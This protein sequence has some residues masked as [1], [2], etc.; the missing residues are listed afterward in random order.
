MMPRHLLKK[1]RSDPIE[2]MERQIR[3][4]EVSED[5]NHDN[6][7]EQRYLAENPDIKKAVEEGKLR[8]G[9]F[10]FKRHGRK[11]HRKQQAGADYGPAIRELR[12]EKATRLEKIFKP[13]VSITRTADG[14]FDFTGEGRKDR[15]NF[16]ETD[17][18]S[19]FFYDR[20]PLDI[21]NGLPDGLILDCGAGF[22]PVYYENVVNYE[23]VP[24][25]TTDVLG[26]AE[27][28]PFADNS[29]DAVFSFAVLEHVKLPF[30]AAAEIARVL[31]PGGKL[32]VSAAFLQPMHGYPHHY[33][34]M[35]KNGMKVLFEEHLDIETQFVTEGTGPISSLTWF[36]QNWADALSKKDRKKF[37]R[38]RI[39][40]FIGR[41]TKYDNQPFITNLPEEK[42]SELAGATFLVGRKKQ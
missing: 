25:P 3:T 40:D 42:N 10:H 14:V 6:F 34:N 13:G 29:F 38:M 37:A 31:K 17:K 41:S 11:E 35:T 32:A 19:S 26:F 8:S 16:E 30:Q 28:L 23:I 18:V 5:V 36:L 1:S 33:F 39:G 12:M 24:Y 20:L 2:K 9:W 22:R 15:F 4:V 7:N 21:I 27:D